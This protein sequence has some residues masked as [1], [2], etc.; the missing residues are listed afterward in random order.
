MYI[1]SSGMQAP[2]RS[3]AHTPWK[4]ISHKSLN[5]VRSISVI[6][7]WLFATGFLYWDYFFFFFLFKF[8]TSLETC[9]LVSKNPIEQKY[10]IH[11]TNS[12]NC[13][14]SGCFVLIHD[15]I[16]SSA[17]R[18]ANHSFQLTNKYPSRHELLWTAKAWKCDLSPERL[19][20]HKRSEKNP[21]I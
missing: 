10:W 3:L 19:K 15:S 2:K 5:S 4:I 8:L 12:C 6:A 21:Q 17:V 16:R 20:N 13:W 1:F 11:I 7:G 14:V 9:S 18:C